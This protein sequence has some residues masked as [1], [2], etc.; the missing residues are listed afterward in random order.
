MKLTVPD[1]KKA[2]KWVRLTNLLNLFLAGIAIGQFWALGYDTPF[3]MGYF[4]CGPLLAL[5]L[6]S[7]FTPKRKVDIPGGLLAY[8]KDHFS[9]V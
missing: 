9:A 5:I 6:D 1:R 3:V 8:I 7:H 4:I 2:P